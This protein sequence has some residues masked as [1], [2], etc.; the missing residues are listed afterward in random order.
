MEGWDLSTGSSSPAGCPGL[1]APVGLAAWEEMP[2]PAVLGAC[3]IQKAT[4]YLFLELQCEN[5]YTRSAPTS[6]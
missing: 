4:F 5:G 2:A 1:W 3:L 6:I